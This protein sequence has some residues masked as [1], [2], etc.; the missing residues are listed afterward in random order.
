MPVLKSIGPQSPVLHPLLGP[1]A[2]P[3][4]PR[5]PI[6]SQRD[7]LRL[8]D[9]PRISSQRTANSIGQRWLTEKGYRPATRDWQEAGLLP[10]ARP[11]DTA[12][13]FDCYV[14][15][16]PR[17]RVFYYPSPHNLARE[18]SWNF[19][20]WEVHHARGVPL[21]PLP[22]KEPRSGLVLVVEYAKDKYNSDRRL[23]GIVKRGTSNP[24]RHNSR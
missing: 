8:M 1:R 17:P 15:P 20:A 6:L 16:V 4:T 21:R 13:E 12:T 22:S 14:G 19:G 23:I 7:P 24:T 3:Y 5:Q 9:Q 2:T 11:V 18:F 10:R